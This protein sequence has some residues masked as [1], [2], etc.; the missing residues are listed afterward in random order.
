MSIWVL[1]EKWK[2]Y[3]AWKTHTSPLSGSQAFA[4][5]CH[6]KTAKIIS[7]IYIAW[8]YLYIPFFGQEKNEALEC[9]VFQLTWNKTSSF[10]QIIPPSCMI[11][12]ILNNTV[13]IME[14]MTI[15]YEKDTCLYSIVNI[16][17]YLLLP[18]F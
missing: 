13:F 11:V 3:S 15:N 4:Q 17:K 16:K 1:Y 6:L 9:P 14:A 5:I 18:K 7:N 10:S 12:C 8:K 2:Y